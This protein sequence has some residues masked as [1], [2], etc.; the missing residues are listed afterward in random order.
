MAQYAASKATSAGDTFAADRAER[1]IDD[2]N[3]RL[4]NP[5]MTS[6]TELLANLAGPS[7]KCG[8]ANVH[9]CQEL[10]NASRAVMRETGIKPTGRVKAAREL[11]A[12]ADALAGLQ[13]LSVFV[14]EL[15]RT[16]RE[17]DAG[18]EAARTAVAR[19]VESLCAIVCQPLK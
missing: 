1:E 19:K 2:L 17:S 18:I 10:R 11:K 16:P 6:A 9:D 4:G 7:L 8:G 12:A 5:I 3:M 15:T 14:E 13:L